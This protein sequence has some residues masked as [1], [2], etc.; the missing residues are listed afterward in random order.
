MGI[1]TTMP[2]YEHVAV[3][4]PGKAAAKIVSRNITWCFAAGSLYT[5]HFYRERL[6]RFVIIL[7]L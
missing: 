6:D 5:G 1:N 4:G 2:E 7:D 3:S